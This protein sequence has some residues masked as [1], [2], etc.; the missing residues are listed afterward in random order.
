[1][2]DFQEGRVNNYLRYRGKCREMALDMVKK[3]PGLRL[4]RGFYHCPFWGKQ[5][6]WWAEDKNGNVIDP[7]AAQFPSNGAGEYEEFNGV[8]QCEE[9]GKEVLED[10]AYIDGNHAFCSGECFGRF[11]GL[12]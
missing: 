11:V 3:Y 2:A 12:L 7:S 5:A 10:D 8:I 4:V 1:M 6:H 9:C